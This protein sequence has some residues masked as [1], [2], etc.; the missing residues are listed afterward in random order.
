MSDKKSDKYNYSIAFMKFFF[1]FCV[2]CAHFWQMLSIDVFPISIMGMMTNAAAPSF[3][4]ISFYLTGKTYRSKEE[5]LLANR[6][7]RLS[8]PQISWAVIYFTSFTVIGMI[9][10]VIKIPNDFV[11]RFTKKDLLLQAL[12]GSDRYLCP[13]FWYQ[14][15]LIVFTI[16]IWCIYRFCEKYAVKI[17]IFLGLLALFLQYSGINYRLFCRFEFEF[18]YPLGRL[19][20]SLPFAV[21]GVLLLHHAIPAKTRKHRYYAVFITALLIMILSYIKIIPDP[22]YG[23]D[24]CGIQLII[25]TIS[26]FILFYA[27]PFEKLTDPLKL[28]LKVLSKYSFGVFCIHLGIGMIWERIICYYLNINTGSFIECVMIYSVSL[29]LAV[30]I[31]KIPVRFTKLLVT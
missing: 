17:L 20:E 19:A 29:A 28:A 18:W 3:F 15:V 21:V 10:N 16:L 8:V 13:Q 5:S 4:V 14:F 30:L 12:F 23:F 26:V 7:L 24:Y 22:E 2:V 31:Y 1:S 27:I 11:I 25:F 9:L 6:L